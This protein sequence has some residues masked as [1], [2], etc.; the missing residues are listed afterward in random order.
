MRKNL[1]GPLPSYIGP[2]GTGRVI[3]LSSAVPKVESTVNTMTMASGAVRTQWGLRPSTSYE[4]TWEEA[5]IM[6]ANY[7]KSLRLARKK[8]WFIDGYAGATNALPLS[9]STCSREFWN[10]FQGYDVD[11]STNGLTWRNITDENIGG[12]DSTPIPTSITFNGGDGWI[13]ITVPAFPG[14]DYCFSLYTKDGATSVSMGGNL[15]SSAGDSS[16]ERIS[17]SGTA[18]SES[19]NIK[20]IGITTMAGLQLTWGTT[21]LLPWT[22]GA[23]LSN[24]IISDIAMNYTQIVDGILAPCSFTITEAPA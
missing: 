11:A 19:I 4:C 8:I 16:W 1:E 18:T 2:V 22:L 14:R 17:V 6:D 10:E 3:E 20:I 9:W 15:A 21:E 23:A 5:T 12:P 7:L 24:G 13:S